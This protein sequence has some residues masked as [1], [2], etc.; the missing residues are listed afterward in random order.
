LRLRSFVWL[1]R[2]EWRELLVSRAWWMLLVL[3]GPLVGVSFLGAVRT[4]AEVSGL[5]GA[6]TDAGEVLSPLIGVWAPTFSACELAA[7]FLL[8]FVAIRIAGADRQS[9]AAKLELQATGVSPLARIL[10]KAAIAL[11]G[12]LFAMLPAALAIA[13]WKHYGGAT[14]TPELATLFCGHIL[15]AGLTI[16]IGFAAASVTTHPS[17]AAILTLSVTV[18]TWIIHF[19]AAIQ[20]GIWE[21]IASFTPSAVVADFQH[22]LLRLDALLA[23]TG[24]VLAGLAIAAGW[25]RLG[26]H[27]SR[28]LI[29]TAILLAVASAG[30]FTASH[31]KSSW[32]LSENRANSFPVADEQALRTLPGSLR[33]E[34]HLAPED[35]RRADLERNVFS[36]LRRAV[37][38]D[39]DI[40]YIA[41]TSTG[42]FEQNQAGYGEIWYEY[43]GR[44]EMSRLTTV[45]GVLETIYTM[46][47]IKLPAD[48]KETAYRGRPFTASPD[49]AATLFYGLWPATALLAGLLV[50]RRF[51]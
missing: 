27:P 4:Y 37:A 39:L 1:V 7:V 25:Q 8:P 21:R 11:V 29:E 3:M 19:F 32:D 41:A 22:G 34:V 15:N 38:A 31:V 18:G 48:V 51:H 26:V 50:Q 12:W 44:R 47:A 46:A 45:E 43:N 20:G 13:V 30:L 33:I 17:T 49:G 36:K 40:R 10:A 9:G 14:Y 24:I 42:L 6:A 35:P 2:K 28:R 23:A 5:N 16:G